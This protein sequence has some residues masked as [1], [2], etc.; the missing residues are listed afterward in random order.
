[1]LRWL[2]ILFPRLYDPLAVVSVGKYNIE[3]NRPKKFLNR[4]MGT[5]LNGRKLRVGL[6]NDGYYIERYT[7]LLAFGLLMCATI[8]ITCN[9]P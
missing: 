2:R 1:M 9:R 7:Q 4:L 6:I 8:N 5:I 3:S